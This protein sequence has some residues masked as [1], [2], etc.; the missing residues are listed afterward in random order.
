MTW[1]LQAVGHFLQVATHECSCE[2]RYAT[3]LLMFIMT[4]DLFP[5]QPVLLGC[6]LLS[7]VLVHS[8]LYIADSQLATRP[9]YRIWK[10][11]PRLPGLLL[12]WSFL[13]AGIAVL[14]DHNN[15]I[16]PVLTPMYQIFAWTTFVTT[17]IAV[18][19]V[20]RKAG[21]YQ[22]G[23]AHTSYAT[24]L[25]CVAAAL[26]PVYLL[27]SVSYETILFGLIT[28]MV[29]LS[30]L[31]RAEAIREQA[32]GADRGQTD[33][34]PSREKDRS[35]LQV[36]LQFDECFSLCANHIVLLW[37]GFFASGNVASISS[38][39]LESAYRFITVYAPATMSLLLITKI[40]LPLFL[41]MAWF[42]A[43]ALTFS[44]GR[45]RVVFGAQL[46]S[47]GLISALTLQ[48]LFLVKNDASWQDI[49][50]SITHFAIGC[51][52]LIGIPLIT[53]VTTACM[54]DFASQ[55]K[56]NTS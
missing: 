5:L 17:P 37:F 47:L 43:M 15:V 48:F 56:T 26:Q 34:S 36:V 18:T 21:Q 19:R 22:T 9:E 25:A 50:A 1:L 28:L 39:D 24:A 52:S 7:I 53:A 54:K 55:H 51:G 8:A 32:A 23:T 29:V 14:G 44:A 20:V 41:G 38:F 11:C 30:V 6:N 13:A 31:V 49:G 35:Q 27:M 42:V 2:A 12:V 16:L 4:D 40:F 3:L 33:G 46:T 10:R 45:P